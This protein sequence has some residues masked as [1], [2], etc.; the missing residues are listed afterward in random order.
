M[1]YTVILEKCESGY[2]VFVLDLPGC[3]VVGENREEARRLLTEAVA[4]HVEGLRAE[5][6]PV[7]P[8]QC[9]TAQMERAVSVALWR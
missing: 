1:K 7:P 5:G 9:E 4:Y 6:L 3:V 8:P 2:G